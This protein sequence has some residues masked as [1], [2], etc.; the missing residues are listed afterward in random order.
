LELAVSRHPS[1]EDCKRR[2]KTWHK[3]PGLTKLGNSYFVENFNVLK[4]RLYLE[5]TRRL[6]M[7]KCILVLLLISP[8]AFAD[9][10]QCTQALNSMTQLIN[11]Y[12]GA[13]TNCKNMEKNGETDSR[14][15]EGYRRISR[16]TEQT[17]AKAQSTCYEVCD[18]TFFC[19]GSL[20]GAC[21][22]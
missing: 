13:I 17:Y 10:A 19:E 4:A 5:P 11:V 9:T 16:N 7:K 14:Y 21:M 1:L 20:S 12:V 6:P 2:A 8:A 15:Y 22:N 3:L 18:D